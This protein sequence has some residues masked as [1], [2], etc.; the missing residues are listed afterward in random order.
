MERNE[1]DAVIRQGTGETIANVLQIEATLAE[2]VCTFALHGSYPFFA[3][4]RIRHRDGEAMPETCIS[5]P[6]A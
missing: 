5:D 6:P 4:E 1:V 2:Y 3:E